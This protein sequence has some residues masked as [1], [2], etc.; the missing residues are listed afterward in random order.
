M[1]TTGQ[2]TCAAWLADMEGLALGKLWGDE[3]LETHDTILRHICRLHDT[4]V[5]Q[6]ERTS[7]LSLSRLGHEMTGRGYRNLPCACGQQGNVGR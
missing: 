4:S 1:P 3:P 5:A 6:V 7:W 2:A